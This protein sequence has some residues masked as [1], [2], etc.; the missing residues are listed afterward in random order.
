MPSNL[1]ATAGCLVTYQ[2]K[3]LMILETQAGQKQWDI[4]AGGIE[5]GET[6]EQAVVRELSE[7]T[8][9]NTTEGIRLVRVFWVKG[10][11]NST[12]HFLYHLELK[13]D[14]AE[15]LKPSSLEIEAV[16]FQA[17]D[18]VKQLI[19]SGQYEHPLAKARLELFLDNGHAKE[20]ALEV[21]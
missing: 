4:P 18:F 1:T 6:P 3:L 10:Q 11:T 21:V 5:S 2:G 13:D 20:L 8:G 14:L 19:V 12:V 9:L 16:D 15:K 17:V 7:E